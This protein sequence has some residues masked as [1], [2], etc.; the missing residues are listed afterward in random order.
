MKK[1][2]ENEYPKMGKRPQVR[3]PALKPRS[4]EYD[5]VLAKRR[6]KEKERRLAARKNRGR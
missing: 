5:P 2:N 3:N 6:K 4:K 1:E